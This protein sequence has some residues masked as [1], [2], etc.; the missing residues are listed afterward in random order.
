[1][2]TM[3]SGVISLIYK[4]SLLQITMSVHHLHVI[5]CALIMMATINAPVEMDMY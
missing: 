3:L 4:F 1:M 5:T 2:N